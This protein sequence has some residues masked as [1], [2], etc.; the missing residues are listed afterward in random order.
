MEIP[1]LLSVQLDSFRNF[2]QADVAPPAQKSGHVGDP[3][4]APAVHDRPDDL[5]RLATVVL[6]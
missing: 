3:D 2:L 5:V 6:M 1:N 4:G